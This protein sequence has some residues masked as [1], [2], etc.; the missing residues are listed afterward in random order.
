MAR[1]VQVKISHTYTSVMILPHL[2]F[3]VVDCDLSLRRYNDF[4]K[5]EYLRI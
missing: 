3:R 5:Q 4:L 2:C 1:W